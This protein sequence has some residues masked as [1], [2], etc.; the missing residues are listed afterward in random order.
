MRK[1]IEWFFMLFLGKKAKQVKQ[2]AFIER[3]SAII[4]YANVKKANNKYL[5]KYSGRK[6]YVKT[7]KI[8]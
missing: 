2:E 6:K 8:Y 4:D 3:Q 5:S 7:G 1:I